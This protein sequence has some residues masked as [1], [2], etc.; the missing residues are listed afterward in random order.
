MPRRSN[1]RIT[2]RTVDALHVPD[3]D[4]IFW[5][6][7]ISGFGVRVSV[8]GL[9]TYLVQTRG[10]GGSK[11]VT[12]GPH[13]QVST[14][15][16][17]KQAVAI[18]GRIKQGENP[19]PPTPEPGLTV[20]GLAERFWR[21]HVA[22]NCKERTADI[23]GRA[24]D[25]H[26]LPA[27]GQLPIGSVGRGKTAELHHQLR[28][29]PG[30]ANVVAQVLSRMYTL[31]EAWGLMPPGRN[32]C[33]FIRLYKLRTH[34]RYLTPEEYR[35]LGQ[36][37]R[38]AEAEGSIRPSAIAALR[39]LMLTGCRRD[40]I[41]TLRWDDVDRTARELRLR[42]SK[43]GPRMVALTPALERVLDSI[44]RTPGN[45][46]VIVGRKG[47]H[48]AQLQLQWGRV[49]ARAGL[50]DVRLHD[51]RHSYASRALALG[52]SL[53][54]IGRLLGHV[55]VATTARYA[56]L[57]RDAEKLAAARVGDSIGAHLSRRISEAT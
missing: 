25:N 35:R 26:I 36:V 34:D 12:I 10:P 8:S 19:V 14:D 7:D 41:L 39:L 27:L 46:W 54:M 22:V 28:D 9:R 13:G 30:M 4:A 32:P 1:F 50:E 15:E 43:K 51:L 40:E 57:V 37:L 31:A 49:R 33:R 42:D 55:Q 53:T 17:R 21:L 23:Y 29:K 47:S 48:L 44:P 56:H 20:A 52:E 3:C 5:D 24:L 2:K 16:A 18:I 6:R 11:R 38:E 45:P